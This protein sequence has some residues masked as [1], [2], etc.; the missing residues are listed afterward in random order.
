MPFKLPAEEE[1]GPLAARD[2]HRRARQG[3]R[4]T[5]CAGDYVVAARALVVLR[6]PLDPTA[7]R[8]AA[9]APARVIK[10]AAQRRRRRAGIVIPLFSIRSVDGG[11]GLGEIPDLP[12][13]RH[14]GG[15]GRLLGAAAPARQRGRRRRSQP[16]RGAARRSRSTRSTCRSTPARTSRQP[17]AARR[18]PTGSR[19]RIDGGRGD[20]AL[21][22]WPAVRDAEARRHRA[23]VRTLPARRV[24]AAVAARA[25]TCRRSCRANRAWLDDY[26][27]FTVLHAEQQAQ[28][29]RLAGAAPRSRS[30]RDRGGPARARATS[31]SRA[32][33]VQWQLDLQWRRARREASARRRRA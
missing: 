19:G 3:R 21:V 12:H 33:W 18:C 32:Q 25:S 2:R 26:A 28:L 29:A 23:R 11:W 31:C 14:L 16:L 10:Q 1:G 8:A 24:A 9:G 13:V 5:P 4:D 22:D 15:P 7:A 17:A 20:R 27:L 6:Q 30:G